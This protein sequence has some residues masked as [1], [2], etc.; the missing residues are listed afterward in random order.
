MNN[1]DDKSLQFESTLQKLEDLFEKRSTKLYYDDMYNSE[2]TIVFAG[3]THSELVKKYYYEDHDNHDIIH[4]YEDKKT[5]VIGSRH[6][7][8]NISRC[9]VDNN[10][11]SWYRII[12]DKYKAKYYANTWYMSVWSSYNPQNQN[13]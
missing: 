3:K 11:V 13:T 1:E 2:A 10:C 4:E 6:Y 7:C 9:H 12:P 5:L 8:G